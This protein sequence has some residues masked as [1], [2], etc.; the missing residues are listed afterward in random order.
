M[1]PNSTD[2]LVSLEVE[3]QGHSMQWRG[4]AGVIAGASNSVFW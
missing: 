1:K 4:Q 3:R 2:D